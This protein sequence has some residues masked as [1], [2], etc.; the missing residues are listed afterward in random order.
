MRTPALLALTILAG[1]GSAQAAPQVYESTGEFFAAGDFDGDGRADALLIDKAA[2]VMRIGY[3]LAAE[4]WT[5]V[6]ARPAGAVPVTAVALG[7]FLNATR[8]AIAVTSPAANRVLIHPASSP[9][10]AD[11]PLTHYDLVGPDALAPIPLPDF[12]GLAGRDQIFAGSAN[13]PN[14]LP[15]Y[16]VGIEPAGGLLITLSLDAVHRRGQPILLKT[17]SAAGAAFLAGSGATVELR[18]YDGILG[19]LP[20]LVSGGVASEAQYASAKFNAASPLSRVIFWTPGAPQLRVRPVT[21]PVAGSFALGAETSYTLAGNITQLT[22]LDD[23]AGPRLLVIFNDGT[24][25]NIF[26]F[27]GSSAP[28]LVTSLTPVAGERFRTATIAGGGNFVLTSSPATTTRSAIFRPYHRASAASYTALTA[29]SLPVVTTNAGRANVLVFAEPPFVSPTARPLDALHAG[30]W[31]RSVSL[32]GGSV[33]AVVETFASTSAGLD[34]PVSA[35][36]GSVVAGGTDVLANQFEPYLSISSLRP[37]YD[38]PSLEPAITPLPGSFDTAQ[39]LRFSAPPGVSVNFRLGTG[40]WQ[41]WTGDFQWL[42]D[43]VTVSYYG[44]DGVRS[45]ALRSAAFTFNKDGPFLDSDHDG[46]PDFVEIANG[47]DPR[48]GPDTDG[49]SWNDDTELLA[50][51]NPAD[52]NDPVRPPPPASLPLPPRAANTGVTLTATLQSWRAGA[53]EPTLLPVAD[54]R[55]DAIDTAGTLLAT[56]STTAGNDSVVIGNLAV[57]RATRFLSLT[58]APAWERDDGTGVTHASQSIAIV[59]APGPPPPLVNLYT[60][61]GG[62]PAAEAAAWVAALAA[63][64]AAQTPSVA[65]ATLSPV[66]SLV[67][68]LIERKVDDILIARGANAATRLSL[69]DTGLSD[70]GARRVTPAQLAALELPGPANQAAWRLD[71]MH[72]LID[73]GVK[74]VPG[75]AGVQALRQLAADIYEQFDSVWQ[76]P[77]ATNPNGITAAFPPP[78]DLLRSLARGEALPQA[79]RDLSALN[80]SQ[81]TSAQAA[82]TS[83]L[84]LTTTRPESTLTLTTRADSFRTDCTVFNHGATPVALVDHDSK[85]WRLLGSAALPVGAAAQVRGFTDRPPPPP[86]CAASTLEVITAVVLTLPAGVITDSDGDGLGDEW[87]LAFFGNLNQVGSGDFDGDG[88]TNAQEFAAGTDPAGAPSIAFV[89]PPPDLVAPVLSITLNAAGQIE[90]SW[91]GPKAGAASLR[92]SLEGN[93]SLQEADWAVLSNQPEALPDGR[94]RFTIKP[95]LPGHHFFR[96]RVTQP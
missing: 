87:E 12:G 29:V 93:P 13:D 39:Q 23:P 44:T 51:T 31:S 91:D 7:H 67:A 96:V 25:A 57:E 85:P 20:V 5:W 72:S 48:A 11:A 35:N 95:Q 90:L 1:L 94:M 22:V 4:T 32:G 80:S 37:V 73:Q 46:V 2:G 64:E 56:R 27:N 15:Y 63:A 81:I 69:F 14:A 53:P 65:T 66:D 49:D 77:S 24:S 28:V 16:L 52:P 70:A 74:D 19:S 83:I 17:G 82:I 41:T 43:D 18:V 89:A 21:E 68:L 54:T 75:S 59:P 33:S 92:Y 55:I 84:A 45:S 47:L 36:L 60:P 34:N 62:T 76:P 50:G 9:A 78:I 3:Q 8:D 40:A 30:D 10:A 38:T 58:T 79:Y 42:I 71:L 61:G 26:T 86:A 6:P 88:K